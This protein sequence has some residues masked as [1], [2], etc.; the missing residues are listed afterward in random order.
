[1]AIKKSNKIEESIENARKEWEEC[2]EEAN[3]DI[4][5]ARRLYDEKNPMKLSDEK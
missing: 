5:E 1:M 2:L 4:P 3:G